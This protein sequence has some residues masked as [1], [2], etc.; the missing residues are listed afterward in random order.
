ML[1]HPFPSHAID[2]IDHNLH[3]RVF[4][5]EISVLNLSRRY[6]REKGQSKLVLPWHLD[7]P[8]KAWIYFYM[9]CLS[10]QSYKIQLAK[11]R[12]RRMSSNSDV[13]I[14]GA[15]L[16]GLSCAVRLHPI[17][18]DLFVCGEYQN[19]ASIQWVM[20]SGRQGA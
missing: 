7:I 13:L 11:Q 16:V 4:L 14:I 2:V 3:A 10:W 17:R 5:K 15:G 20:V 8:Q 18:P 9:D 6:S 12:R 19:V 1:L